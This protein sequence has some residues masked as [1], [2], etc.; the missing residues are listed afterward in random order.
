MPEDAKT[1][2]VQIKVSDE[3]Y[4]VIEAKAKKLG[5]NVSAY[6]RLVALNAEVKITVEG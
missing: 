4:S 1:R 2:P 3:E 6:L 5:L